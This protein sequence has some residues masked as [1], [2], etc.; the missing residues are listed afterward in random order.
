MEGRVIRGLT[1]PSKSFLF[2]GAVAAQPWW[3]QAVEV[4]V[5][6]EVA[7]QSDATA[8]LTASGIVG[9][10]TDR[11]RDWVNTPANDLVPVAFAEQI[12]RATR[13]T[14]V[15]CEILDAEELGR[16]G[17][18]GILGVGQGSANPPCL[19]KLTWRPPEP[20]GRS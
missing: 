9:E 2:R 11:A 16:L 6:S 5:L 4:V 7:R 17:C 3:L 10:H 14:A 19:V 12:E 8:A 1:R 13:G 18:G 20:A 15:G